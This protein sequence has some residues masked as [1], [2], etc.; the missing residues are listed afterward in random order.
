MNKY[1]FIILWLLVGFSNAIFGQTLTLYPTDDTYIYKGATGTGNDIRGLTDIDWLRTYLTGTSSDVYSRDVFLKFDVS[2]VVNPDLIE[3]AKLLLFH[4]NTSYNNEHTLNVGLFSKTS[5]SEDNLTYNNKTELVG[6]SVLLASGKTTLNSSAYFEW[7]ITDGLKNQL[8]TNQVSFVTLSLFEGTSEKNTS[9]SGIIVQWH[10]KENASG[11]KPHL[12]LKMKN[13]DELELTDIK[14]NQLS[15]SVF[16]PK[17]FSYLVEVASN[18]TFVPVVEATPQSGTTISYVQA[19]SLDGSEPERTTRIIVCKSEQSVTYKVVFVRKAASNDARLSAITIDN[20]GLP[21]FDPEKYEY[22]LNLPCSYTGVPDVK[23]VSVNTAATFEIQPLVN[24]NGSEVDRTT[25]IVVLSE[26]KQ[27]SKIYKIRFDVLPK[28]DLFLCIGQ[29]NMAGRGYMLEEDNA[30]ISNVFLLNADGNF[31]IAS[32]PLN[33]YSAVRKDLS[34]QQIGPAYSFSKKVA[35]VSVNPVGLIVNARGGTT[36][37]QWLKISTDTL[38]AS[39]IRRAKQATKWGEYKGILWHQGEGNSSSSKVAIYPDQLSS[40]VAD[41]RKDLNNENLF[42][43][44]GELA[45]W[46]GDFS[47]STAFNS[48]INTVS[49]FISNSACVSANALTPL[50]DYTDPHFDR[51]SQLIFG[52]RYADVIINHVYNHN[53]ALHVSESQKPDVYSDGKYIHIIKKQDVEQYDF[54]IRSLTGSLIYKN[55]FSE[56][57]KIRINN[58]GVFIVSVNNQN[59]KVIL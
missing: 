10:S 54:Q 28:M 53:T 56:S 59:F 44:A 5:W 3:S 39:S 17:V 25:N 38:Y 55:S 57:A 40:L 19:T 12:M 45:Y 43:V 9:N 33:K 31:E 1:S 7:D 2:E 11:N 15:L 18:E 32:N 21:A 20:S 49:T 14:I 24:L 41:I 26:D 6:N 50:I 48:M 37:E 34:I 4:N 30:P 22:V 52:E 16:N 35:Q 36:I 47:G 51:N 42:F 29:S 46:R 27:Q 8:T 23:A 58:N 13:T